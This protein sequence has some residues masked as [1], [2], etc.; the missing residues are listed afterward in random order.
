MKIHDVAQGTTAWNQLR[1]GI[2]TASMF[3]S[4]ITPGGKKSDAQDRYMQH[5]IAERI[6]G[7]YIDGFKSKY[8]ELGNAHESRAIASYELAH[9]CDTEK[10]GF[11]TTDDGLIG[12]SPDRFIVG[13]SDGMV[14]AKAPTPAVHV[15][16]LLA[17]VG[18]SKEY[19]CQLQGQLWV[20]ERDWVDI[21]SYCDGFPDALFRVNRD[22]VFIKEM[23][24]HVRAFVG[25]LEEN[26]EKLRD[27]YDI[28][29]PEA[30]AF[31]DGLFGIT[32]ADVDEAWAAAEAEA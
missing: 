16:Y 6:R 7:R 12:C 19:R 2:P 29:P 18:A 31:D 8:M 11:V 28:K 21:V 26:M 15:S 3:D 14:E 17:S 23:A 13:V 5:L 30:P 20:C 25:R 9:D 10:V 27:R 32:Q 1:A 22:D 24:A 4:I